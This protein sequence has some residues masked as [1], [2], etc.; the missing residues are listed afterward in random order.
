MKYMNEITRVFDLIHDLKKVLII[1]RGNTLQ[2]FP[3]KNENHVIDCRKQIVRKPC[4]MKDQER[5]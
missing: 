2:S 5:S 4:L 3:F 1:R